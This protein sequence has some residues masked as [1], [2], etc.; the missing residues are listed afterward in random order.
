MKNELFKN[1]E[2]YIQYMLYS[3]NHERTNIHQI[4]VQ[5]TTNIRVEEHITLKRE[6]R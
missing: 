3:L 2:N 1:I 5:V 4:I 6:E